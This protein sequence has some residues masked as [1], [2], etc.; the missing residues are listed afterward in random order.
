MVDVPADAGAGM[1]ML[2]SLHG[3]EGGDLFAK[4]I[5]RLTA[6]FYG[7]VGLAWL[8]YLTANADKLKGGLRG[9]VDALGGAYP[10]RLR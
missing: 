7:A 6:T 4:R 2:E 3:V 10:Y 1:G 8:Q 5:D 9:A